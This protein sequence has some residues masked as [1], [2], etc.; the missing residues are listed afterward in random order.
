MLAVAVVA[1]A[2]G[3]AATTTPTQPPATSAPTTATEPTSPTTLPSSS[4]TT[5]QPQF[6]SVLDVSVPSAALGHDQE[7]TIYTPA[8]YPDSGPLPVVY[9]LHGQQENNRMWLNLGLSDV[10][11]QLIADG[12]I[13][14]LLIVMPDIDNSFG[15]NNEESALVEVPNGPLVHYDGN[16]YEDFLAVD[17]IDY[18]DTNY[19]TITDRAD[20]YVGGISMGGFAAIHLA[21]RHPGLF[22]RVGGHSPALIRDRDFTW[23]YPPDVALDTRD[24]FLIAEKANLAGLAVYLDVGAQD[25][26]GFLEPTE[27]MAR[28]LS[29]LGVDVRLEVRDGTH[30]FGYWRSNL[31]EY[32][33]FYAHGNP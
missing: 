13:R 25:E 5:S 29:D 19:E 15:V 18:I 23:L 28:L 22:S 3:Q 26:W 11:D 17:L 10:A 2:A 8:G 6:G 21:F 9:L 24:P 31:P 16:H 27:E 32:L 1:C 7:V 12:S 30:S 4:T 33:S 20:R 14:P